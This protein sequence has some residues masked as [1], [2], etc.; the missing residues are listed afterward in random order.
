MVLIYN[1]FYTGDQTAHMHGSTICMF[2]HVISTSP[3][4]M[5]G[6]STQ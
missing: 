5:K 6:F 2:Q 4:R 3:A 1:A